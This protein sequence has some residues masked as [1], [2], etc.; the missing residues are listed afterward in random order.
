M[1]FSMYLLFSL[2]IISIFASCSSI[3]W[4]DAELNEETFISGNWKVIYKVIYKEKDSWNPLM[5]TTEKKNYQTLI[6]LINPQGKQINLGKVNSW[7]LPGHLVYQSNSDSLFWIQGVDDGYGTMNRKAGYLRNFQKNSFK[8]AEFWD[9][10]PQ[11]L[12]VSPSPNSKNVAFIFQKNETNPS[13]Y[14]GMKKT[15]TF[16]QKNLFESFPIPT[17]DE[18]NCND[19]KSNY[20]LEWNSDTKLTLHIERKKIEWE[21][22]KGLR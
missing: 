20:R 10:E 19:K 21:E 6:T 16:S 12:C 17:W 9:K 4:R 7:I 22:G 1:K 8:D 2:L 3:F 11:L 13:F 5:G 14:L 18:M 15:N